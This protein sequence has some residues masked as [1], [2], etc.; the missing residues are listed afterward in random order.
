MIGTTRA[1]DLNQS[2]TAT[3]AKAMNA[4]VMPAT[5]A[6]ALALVPCYAASRAA[7]N[8]PASVFT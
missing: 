3:R 8:G 4:P 7:Q 6:S 1:G 5:K 2:N